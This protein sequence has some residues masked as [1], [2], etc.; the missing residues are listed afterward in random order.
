[1]T[2]AEVGGLSAL[3]RS[4][5]QSALPALKKLV[6]GSLRRFPTYK[7]EDLYPVAYEAAALAAL[8]YQPDRGTTFIMFAWQRSLGAMV[9]FAARNSKEGKR[10]EAMRA[11]LALVAEAIVDAGDPFSESEADRQARL[12]ELRYASAAGM[13]LGLLQPTTPEEAFLAHEERGRIE[14]GLREALSRQPPDQVAA[15]EARFVRGVPLADVFKEQGVAYDTGQ[16]RFVRTLAKIGAVLATQG[17]GPEAVHA[18]GDKPLGVLGA[19]NTV[20]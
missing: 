15:I 2:A 3:Q 16:K 19:E 18:A 4:W 1:M 8:R 14:A 6:T 20:P 17:I 11:G 13:T 10:L 5:L 7:F 9:R 12:D